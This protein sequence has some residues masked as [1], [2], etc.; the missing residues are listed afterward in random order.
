MSGTAVLAGLL[1]VACQYIGILGSKHRI[2]KILIFA[3]ILYV[4]PQLVD[5][6]A[7]TYKEKGGWYNPIFYP[8]DH[9]TRGT[10]A[11]DQGMN[12]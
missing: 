6:I 2:F 3:G 1:F 7:D 11:D 9:Y 5:F 10:V 12:I 4:I 8:P